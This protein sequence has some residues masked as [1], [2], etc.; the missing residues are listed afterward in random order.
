MLLDLRSLEESSGSITDV[1]FLNNA[2]VYVYDEDDDDEVW[3][4]Q[5]VATGVIFNVIA[6][7]VETD[8]TDVADDEDNWQS[9]FIDL[10]VVVVDLIAGFCAEIEDDDE[11]DAEIWQA[12]FI[13][14]LIIATIVVTT[15]AEDDDTEDDG[16]NWQAQTIDAPTIVDFIF[17]SLS[18]IEDEEDDD[19]IGAAS[20]IDAPVNFP[21]A[22]GNADLEDEIDDD[23]D[24]F[25]ALIVD[26]F[27]ANADVIQALF[28]VDEDFADDVEDN[29]SQN[30]YDVVDV[31]NQF[32]LDDDFDDDDDAWQS[33][34]VYDVPIASIIVASYTESDD[35]A[36]DDIDVSVL[37]IINDVQ[38]TADIIQAL[39]EV[40]EDFA[41]DDENNVL[42]LPS[43][44]PNIPSPI[45]PIDTSSAQG[46]GGGGG[47][48]SSRQESARIRRTKRSGYVQFSEEMQSQNDQDEL[49]FIVT[50][51]VKENLI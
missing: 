26:Q 8:D 7:T 11:L 25:I 28:E 2:D 35:D 33:A 50:L 38:I 23:A 5:L 17:A 36:D 31:I 32:C 42:F 30:L 27:Q 44:A 45:P 14:D 24:A 41:D 6:Q 37:Q 34:N 15:V 21:I 47:G 46:G 12:Q 13:V 43:D 18:E 4:P 39:F 9:Q 40:D 22:S 1:S 10:P 48:R 51:L 29:P 49:L 20:Y 19:N 3:Q 16:D